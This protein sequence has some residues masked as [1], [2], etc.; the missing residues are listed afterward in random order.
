MNRP[1]VVTERDR[2]RECSAFVRWG[3]RVGVP[4]T[5]TTE[6]STGAKVLAS[7]VVLT[8][9]A[10]VVGVG[11]FGTFTDRSTPLD[12]VLGD[13]VVSLDVSG[14]HRAGTVPLA[15]DGVL[16]GGSTTRT[17]SLVNDG[18]ADLASV[19][20]ITTA[21]ISSVLDT[22]SAQGLQL[23]VRS[24]S[25]PWSTDLS[26]AGAERSVLT[27]GPVLRRAPLD[28]PA[29]LTAGGT[30]HLAL[31]VFLPESA[32]NEFAGRSSALQFTFTA[33]QRAGRAR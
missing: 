14:P 22:D 18:S 5:G 25:V 16:P 27:A 15:F 23:A 9:G 26:C 21:T 10:A 24:C 1:A 20:L 12:A 13:G 33:V 8:A 6:L 11:T 4:V 17:L 28:R 19:T 30:D 32:G 3:R 7:M 29:S 31:T 2:I